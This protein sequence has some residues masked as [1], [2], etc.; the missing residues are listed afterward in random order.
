MYEGVPMQKPKIYKNRG[1]HKP[2]TCFEQVPLEIVQ[3]IVKEQVEQGIS[4]A[5][6]IDRKTPDNGIPW[7]DESSPVG[8]GNLMA[9]GFGATK[10]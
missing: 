7:P 2:K 9:R 3:K 5:D 4:N 8:V 10:L 1:V 6:E